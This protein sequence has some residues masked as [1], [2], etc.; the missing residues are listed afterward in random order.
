MRSRRARF[1][2]RIAGYLLGLFIVF[3]ACPVLEAAAQE[4]SE[5]EGEKPPPPEEKPSKIKALAGYALS[6]GGAFVVVALVIHTLSKTLKYEQARNAIIHLLRSNPN[7]AELQCATLPH[8]FYDA[9]GAALRTGGMAASTQDMATIQTATVPTYDAISAQV[10]QHW[11]GLVGKTKLAIIAGAGAI[12]LKPGVLTILLGVVA[13]AGV[14]WLMY[15]KSEVERS[16]FRAKVEVLPE[17]EQALVQG[18][19]YVQPRA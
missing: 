14:L 15:Y 12:A 1:A 18:R 4:A 8:S 6:I 3:K 11:K 16:M 7:Q 9:I 19:Y 17:V 10:I 5:T 2:V 13:G